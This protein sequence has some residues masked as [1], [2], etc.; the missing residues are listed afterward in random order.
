MSL[1]AGWASTAA[2]FLLA[3]M[4]AV[5]IFYGIRVFLWLVENRDSVISVLVLSAAVA[6][7]SVWL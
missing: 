1:A 7:A 4:L 2:V 6:V 3:V 5:V